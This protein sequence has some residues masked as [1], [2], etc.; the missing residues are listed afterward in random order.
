MPGTRSRGTAAN[1]IDK[2]PISFSA[3][4]IIDIKK[5]KQGYDI[6]NGKH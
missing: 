5:V 3:L 6:A 1:T 4:V 2:V